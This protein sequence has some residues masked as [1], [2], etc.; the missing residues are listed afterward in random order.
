MSQEAEETRNSALGPP[1]GTSST[2]KRFYPHK[3]QDFCF[4]EL[5]ENKFVF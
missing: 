3:S 2:N 4:V 5:E 1:E